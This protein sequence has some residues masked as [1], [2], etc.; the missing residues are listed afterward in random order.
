MFTKQNANKIYNTYYIFVKSK[1]HNHT[2]QTLSSLSHVKK[3]CHNYWVYVT[4]AD[5]LIYKD[6]NTKI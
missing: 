4:R 5:R 3:I 2:T 6:H 1:W